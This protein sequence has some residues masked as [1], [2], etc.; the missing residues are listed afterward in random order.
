MSKAR[1]QKE[2]LPNGEEQI[3]R[4]ANLRAEWGMASTVERGVGRFGWLFG[5]DVVGEANKEL[6][7]VLRGDVGNEQNGKVLPL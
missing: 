6:H 2:D 5:W 4:D 1:G 3:A 7:R